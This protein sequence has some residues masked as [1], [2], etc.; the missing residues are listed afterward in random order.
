[1][2]ETAPSI[3]R[4]RAEWLTT[5][6]KLTGLT[7]AKL[8]SLLAENGNG[9]ISQQTL[10]Y[11]ESG[12]TDPPPKVFLRLVSVIMDYHDDQHRCYEDHTKELGVLHAN[13]VI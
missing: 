10:S 9:Q 6:R 13:G 2:P 4:T 12:H 5:L 1:M 11:Y 7:Q 3:P 8:V